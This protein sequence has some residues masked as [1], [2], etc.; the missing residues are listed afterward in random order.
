MCLKKSKKVI[1][2]FF[3]SVGSTQLKPCGQLSPTCLP[4]PPSSSSWWPRLGP[5]RLHPLRQ[6]TSS[7]PVSHRW[8]FR[9][10][11]IDKKVAYKIET[12]RP[13]SRWGRRCRTG[14]PWTTPAAPPSFRRSTRTS[15]ARQ[16]GWRS[17]STGERW[18]RTGIT[19]SLG[20]KNNLPFLLVKNSFSTGTPANSSAATFERSWRRTCPAR[21]TWTRTDSMGRAKQQRRPLHQCVRR[22]RLQHLVRHW[23]RPRRPQPR[24]QQR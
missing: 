4:R 2:I 3:Y 6:K 16:A 9:K 21:R 11:N 15:T 20:K 12:N 10:K 13:P 24:Q 17:R 23:R 1:V 8:V 18:Q 7:P 22:A 14:T 19:F 5:R